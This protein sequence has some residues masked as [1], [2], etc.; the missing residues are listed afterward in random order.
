M[1]CV[2]NVGRHQAS[3]NV[4]AIVTQLGDPARKEAQGQRVRCG[5]LNHLT[6]PAFQV[7]QMAQHFAQLI[8]HSPRRHQK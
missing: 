8:D 5:N 7:M 4:Q 1:H 3:G 2:A 6:L